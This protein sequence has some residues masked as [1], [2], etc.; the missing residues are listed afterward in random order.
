MVKHLILDFLTVFMDA[1][2]EAL[3]VLSISLLLEQNLVLV[4]IG[5]LEIILR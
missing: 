2:K 4:S 1:L 3:S 5:S